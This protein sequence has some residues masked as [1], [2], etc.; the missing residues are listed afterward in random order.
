MG[1]DLDPSERDFAHAAAPVDLP[2]LGPRDNDDEPVV[3]KVEL[4]IDRAYALAQLCKRLG[5]VDARELSASE[6]EARLM[7]AACGQVRTA[8]AE[9]GVSVR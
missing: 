4:D 6:E 9:A 8:L 7:L 3:L 2:L 5:L 1:I